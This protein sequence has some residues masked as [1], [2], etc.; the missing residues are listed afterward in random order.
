MR[1]FFCYEREMRMGGYS[2]KYC[3]EKHKEIDNRLNGHDKNIGELYDR[4]GKLEVNKGVVEVKIDNLCKSL[5]SLVVTMRWFIG[6]SLSGFVA[7]I[8][9]IIAK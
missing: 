5:N 7:L 6:I 4:T 3:E 9:Y 1:G 8:G 2:E